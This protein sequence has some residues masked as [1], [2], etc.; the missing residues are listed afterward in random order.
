MGVPIPLGDSLVR[1]SVDWRETRIPSRTTAS[2]IR[3][4][5]EKVNMRTQ[6]VL[7][8]LFVSLSSISCA[9]QLPGGST[10]TPSQD[11]QTPVVN[12]AQTPP[13][14]QFSGSGTVDKLVPGT[15]QIGLLEAID[16]AAAERFRER[17]RVIEPDQPGGIRHSTAGRIEVARGG[18]LWNL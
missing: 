3:Y 14:K 4:L 8:I 11:R 6:R 5:T 1:Q 15:I 17:E 7:I 12:T 18:A 10:P 9:A 2:K 13:L 16:R